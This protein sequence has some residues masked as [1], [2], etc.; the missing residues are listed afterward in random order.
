GGDSLGVGVASAGDIDGDGLDD[1]I[2]GAPVAGSTGEAYLFL[3]ESPLSGLT[4]SA[5][6]SASAIYGSGA[7]DVKQV[8]AGV[9]AGGDLD[10]DGNGDVLIG[11]AGSGSSNQG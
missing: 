11:A 2:A 7:S 5:S 4:G 1:F 9:A 10:G 3:G 6:S 8:G